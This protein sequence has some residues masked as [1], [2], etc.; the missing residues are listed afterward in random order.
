VGEKD[1]KIDVALC[2]KMKQALEQLVPLATTLSYSEEEQVILKEI[3]PLTLKKKFFI[4]NL[5][6]EAIA[7]DSHPYLMKLKEYADK[8]GIKVVPFFGKLEAEVHQLDKSEQE[9]FLK[10]MGI[11]N[12]G[13]MEVIKAGREVLELVTFYTFVGGKELRNWLIP[14]GTPAPRAAGKIHTDFEA[15]FIKADVIGFEEFMKFGSEAEA[16]K[17]GAIRVEGKE[18]LVQDG[19]IIHFKFKA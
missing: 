8:H 7:K 11:S 16:R 14:A 2:E 1:A 18:Y 19:D 6:E 4:A 5:G 13:L 12:P 15:G 9:V 3:R 10:E 17:H